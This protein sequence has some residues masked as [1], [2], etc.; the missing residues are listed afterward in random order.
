MHV[1][2]NHLRAYLA[3]ALRTNIKIVMFKRLIEKIKLR[4]DVKKAK[5]FFRQSA[6][7][8]TKRIKFIKR[9]ERFGGKSFYH[10]Y[11]ADNGVDDSQMNLI[12]ITPNKYAELKIW[13]L[14]LTTA[15]GLGF[16]ME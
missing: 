10:F 1:T 14:A 12:I 6:D 4:R 11:C 16:T 13:E 7:Y 15:I 9:D 5:E 8:K 3:V 2:L